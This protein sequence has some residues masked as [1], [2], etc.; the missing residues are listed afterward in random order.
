MP[1][2]PSPELSRPRGVSH[3]AIRAERYV[4]GVKPI[5]TI[6]VNSGGESPED[7]LALTLCQRAP[8]RVLP[9]APF[10]VA[11][12]ALHRRREAAIELPGRREAAGVRI[13]AG[14]VAGQVGGAAR[15]R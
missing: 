12:C 15:G 4:A 14:L 13:N 11:R 9:A 7:S 5:N 10:A 8:H 6:V 3:A 1:R 2:Q